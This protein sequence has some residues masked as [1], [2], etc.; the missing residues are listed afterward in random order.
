M[1]TY[2]S[3][4][5]Y[6]I[7]EPIKKALDQ[8]GF[9]EPLEVQVATFDKIMAGEDLVVQSQTGSGKTAAFA[10]PILEA[11]D[12]E[13]LQPQ[14]LIL[15]PTR[16]LAQQVMEDFHQIGKLKGVKTLAVFGKEPIE[17][18]R[19][20][21]KAGV[22]VLVATPGRMM[23]HL[24]QKNVNLKALKT[25]VLD[26]ADEMLLMGFQEQIDSI[27]HHIK[28]DHQTLLFSAT[29][30]TE[31]NFLCQKY[32]RRPEHIE[33]ESK[34][35]NIEKIDQLYYA[36]D[37]LKKVDFIKKMIRHERPEK[38]ILFCNTQEQVE[39]LFAIFTK[40]EK[41]VCA[42]HGGMPQALRMEKIKGFKKG[43]YRILISTDLLS[44]GLHVDGITHVINYGVPFENEQYVH[45]IGRTGR[46]T[47][48]GVAITMV[49]PSE[50][51]RFNALQT[52][53]GYEI[54]CRGG[55][56]DKAQFK[57]KKNVADKTR[58]KAD[59]AKGKGKTVQINAGS[60]NSSLSKQ[61]VLYALRKMP[62]LNANDI[63]PVILK[64]KYSTVTI[65][66]GVERDV[67]KYLSTKPIR[68]RTYRA[69]VTD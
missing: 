3:F 15:A 24:K 9:I 13:L 2:Q 14:A 55:H 32:Q 19:K 65:Y 54:P 52:Y 21:I 69:K 37:G 51:E 49:I 10:I 60:G 36:V 43:K 40:W 50:M 38:C 57:N 33:I 58:F 4:K 67:A 17:Y 26:E 46:V 1:S 48:H 66:G 56:V 11:I 25:V 8:L 47:E 41:G 42:V 27:M 28:G 16:E 18:Q 6:P 35:P 61:D 44:R 30:P 63:G 68:N 45:R 22:H 7:G 39:N 34:T 23:D 53:L 20:A 12:V 62:G 29:L 5:D 59:K 31:V 64:D